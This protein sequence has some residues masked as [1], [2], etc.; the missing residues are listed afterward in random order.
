MNTIIIHHCDWG[1][2]TMLVLKYQMT[3]DKQKR[4]KKPF[5]LPKLAAEEGKIV[6]IDKPSLLCERFNVSRHGQP[7]RNTPGTSDIRLCERFSVVR[8]G[9]AK[10]CSDKDE[11]FVL[12]IKRRKSIL[13]YGLISMQKGNI[14]RSS[15]MCNLLQSRNYYHSY[16]PDCKSWGGS[17]NDCD[18]FT[19]WRW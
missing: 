1:G 5:F 18:Y 16:E 3:D 7:S 17:H 14:V 10:D 2:G 13:K 4:Q 19:E 8:H 9:R 12:E 6:G 15:W 11:M